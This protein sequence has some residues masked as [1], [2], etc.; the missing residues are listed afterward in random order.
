MSKYKIAF[1][2]IDGTI[3]NHNIHDWDHDSI[4]ALK[5]AQ[6]NGVLIFICTARPYDSIVKTGLFNIFKPDG[7][8][9]TNGALAYIGNKLLFENRFPIAAIKKILK[10]CNSHN[11][12]LEISSQ[13]DRYFT[14]LNNIWLKRYKKKYHEI[15]INNK[16]IDLHKVSALLLFAPSEYDEIIN[17]EFPDPIKCLR[18][19]DY[20]VDVTYFRNNKGEAV[21]KVLTYLNIDKSKSISCGDDFGDIPM[22]HETGLSIALGNAKE[23]VKKEASFITKDIS[24]SGVAH[25]FETFKII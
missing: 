4:N 1:I 17:H 9:S 19:D 20:A 3:L 8:I 12:C 22:F 14:R 15:F 6:L 23:E 7:V 21:R 11:L 10:V 24:L 25:A 2:D 16:K 5:K 13:K 18:F